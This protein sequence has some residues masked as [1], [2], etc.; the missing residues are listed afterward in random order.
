MIET[1]QLQSPGVSHSSV[2][3]E[4]AAQESTQVSIPHSILQ[5]RANR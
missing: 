1:D 2:V 5:K 4:D 3:I